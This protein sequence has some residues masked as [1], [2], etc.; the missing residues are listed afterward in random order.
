MTEAEIRETF[1]YHSPDPRRVQMHEE[2]RETITEATVKIAAMLPT[3]RERSLFITDMQRA[4]MMAN[5]AVAIHVP[6]MNFVQM[7]PERK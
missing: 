2:I 7:P 5:A 6:D 3:S 1:R 4:Q